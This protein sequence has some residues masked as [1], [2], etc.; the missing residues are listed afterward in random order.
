MKER[1]A[2]YEKRV[3]EYEARKAEHD[4]RKAEYNVCLEKKIMG[5]KDQYEECRN[6]RCD[7]PKPLFSG[8]VW[9]ERKGRWI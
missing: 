9:D 4:A 3:A 7:P 2:E 6:R 8:E 1:Q 5:L